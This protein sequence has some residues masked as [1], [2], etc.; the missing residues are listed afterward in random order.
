MTD[1]KGLKREDFNWCD[2][3]II[4]TALLLKG[5]IMDSFGNTVQGNVYY[6]V[7]KHKES[8]MVVILPTDKD[9]NKQFDNDLMNQQLKK[10]GKFN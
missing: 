10:D 6:E 3:T 8:G 9:F 4:G 5:G 1:P 2:D 7:G